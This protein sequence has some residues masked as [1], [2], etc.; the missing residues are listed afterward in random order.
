MALVEIRDSRLYREE[1]ETFEDYC[2]GRWDYTIRHCDR[3]MSAAG[4]V[5]AL[6]SGPIGL[7]P[8]NEAQVRPL[9]QLETA[10]AQQ[11]AWGTAVEVEQKNHQKKIHL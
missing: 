9:T 6:E 10:E 2:K 7:V 5:K 1:Y 8:Q 11:E 4:T 3:L